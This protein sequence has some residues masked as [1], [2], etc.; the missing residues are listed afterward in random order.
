MGRLGMG[1]WEYQK[2]QSCKLC[3]RQT[4]WNASVIILP[5]PHDAWA[6]FCPIFNFVSNGVWASLNLM[7]G[8]FEKFWWFWFMVVY[9]G[10]LPGKTDHETNIGIFE[11][12]KFLGRFYPVVFGFWARL[13]LINFAQASCGYGY[14]YIFILDL[15]PVYWLASSLLF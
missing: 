2:F 3:K 1:Y 9:G 14:T 13:E 5:Y 6:Y 12:L 4:E 15:A 11:Q 8:S 7:S 10:F